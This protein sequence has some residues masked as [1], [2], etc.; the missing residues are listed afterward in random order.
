MSAPSPNPDQLLS[1]KEVR[2]EYGLSEN[3][4]EKLAVRGGGPVMT[5]ISARMVR[6]RRCDIEGWLASKRIENS[7]QFEAG[8]HTG[9]AG[10]IDQSAA[11]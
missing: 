8:E 2:E 7:A 5:K 1:R 3:L 9:H 11:V 4:L 6:Y 10:H